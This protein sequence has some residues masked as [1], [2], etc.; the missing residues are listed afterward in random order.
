MSLNFFV[1]R[2]AFSNEMSTC[3]DRILGSHTKEMKGSILIDK[4]AKKKTALKDRMAK[5]RN[6]ED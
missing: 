5:R 3:S 1:T 4:T 6:A 2:T